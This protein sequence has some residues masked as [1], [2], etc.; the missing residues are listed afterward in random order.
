ML[1]FSLKYLNLQL[2]KS[3][4]M[5][6]CTKFPRCSKSI[7][8]TPS[9]CLSCSPPHCCWNCE[10][11]KLHQELRSRARGDKLGEGSKWRELNDHLTK[12]SHTWYEL[13]FPNRISF[14]WYFWHPLV[15]RDGQCSLVLSSLGCFQQ[16]KCAIISTIA[17]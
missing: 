10:C 15:S 3:E 8:L 14:A 12:L 2:F 7:Y 13:K 6:K 17:F 5:L 9:S 4:C 16:G 1:F 11:N